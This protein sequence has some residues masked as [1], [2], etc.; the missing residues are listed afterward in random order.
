M[1]I[2]FANVEPESEGKPKRADASLPEREPDVDAL[3]ESV[4][5][6]LPQAKP[7]PKKR[8]RK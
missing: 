4:D 1:A 3:K 6:E 8:G 7:A 2:K 5:P